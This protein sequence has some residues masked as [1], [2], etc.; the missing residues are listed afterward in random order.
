MSFEIEPFTLQVDPPLR[1]VKER[2]G[3]H[4]RFEHDGLRG[5]GEA[6]AAPEL[7]TEDVEQCREALLACAARASAL[8]LDL[9]GIVQRLS[10]AAELRERPAARHGVELALL[11]ALA[12]R[13]GMSLAR[14][15]NPAA[16][17]AVELSGLLR[18]DVPAAEA[19]RLCAE[20]YRS[21]KAKVGLRTPPEEA[22][23]LLAVRRAVGP[24]IHLRVDANGAWSE[25]GARVALRGLAPLH[26]ALCEQPV[27]SAEVAS[28]RRLK[29][30][31]LCQIAAD[32]AVVPPELRARVLD[33]AEGA[34]A[35]VLV[36]KPMVLGGVL[37]ALSIAREALALGVGAYVT[38]SLD[39]TLARAGAAQ[40][41]AALPTGDWASGI[42]LR[43]G[44][45]PYPVR[46]GRAVLPDAPGLGVGE[47]P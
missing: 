28:L 42:F 43:D 32:E 15:L 7:G 37:T 12:R 23:R 17:A 9:P 36:L 30:A 24:G 11:D 4:V 10:S 44:R 39:G 35:D 25:A 38:T 21:L 18:T 19:E 46:D 22:R 41:A 20:G 26:L 3:F 40:L 6:M 8:P 29:G 2:R 14:L 33:S 34:A 45:D 1:S 13:E 31:G 27:A 16:R 5:L 47:V